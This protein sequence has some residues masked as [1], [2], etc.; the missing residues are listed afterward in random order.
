[1]GERDN[2]FQGP[3][4]NTLVYF[5]G[6]YYIYFESYT[7]P[8]AILSV[9]VARAN[10][11]EGPYEI[12]TWDG[13]KRNPT[14]SL[15]RPVIEP[16]IISVAGH[17][18]VAENYKQPGS[19]NPY[20]LLYGAGWPRGITQKDGKIYL[21]YIDT[22]RFF[23]YKDGN[24][25]IQSFGRSHEEQ[26]PYQLVAIGDDPTS[27]EKNYDNVMADSR[28]EP[29]WNIFSPR[30]F[31]EENKFYNFELKDLNGVNSVVYRSSENGIVWSDQKTLGTV[32]VS[33]KITRG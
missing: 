31:P 26:I 6:K 22:T 2:L 10:S 20:N 21:Y 25:N 30:Y 24:G 7:P 13:W 16:N 1:M 8:S 19:G 11:P 4:A 12:W 32:N 15:W 3:C 18:Y 23:T 27:L 28:G 17:D 5:E 9:F 14:N 29:L 33:G